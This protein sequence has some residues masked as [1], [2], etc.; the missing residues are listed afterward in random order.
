MVNRQVTAVGLIK[1]VGLLRQQNR[2][3]VA[4]AKV[5]VKYKAIQCLHVTGHICK[6]Q[7]KVYCVWGSRDLQMHYLLFYVHQRTRCSLIGG[8][9]R[10]LQS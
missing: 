1:V 10:L 2:R 8:T 5:N 7:E 9:N 4:K 6:R 3:L